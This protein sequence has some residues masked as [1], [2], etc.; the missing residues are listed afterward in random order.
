MANDDGNP[1]ARHGGLSYLE[2]PTYD[3]E[4]SAAFYEA[5]LGWRIDRRGAGDIRFTDGDGLLLG[6]FVRALAPSREP[7]FVPFLYVRD[8]DDALA[9]AKSHGGELVEAAR[10]EGDTRIG[11]VR[12]PAGNVIG[13]WQF[14]G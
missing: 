13:L 6:R 14:A 5:V 7:G 2:V 11:R 4:A 8:I 12:D 9:R 3:P 10:L 1:L